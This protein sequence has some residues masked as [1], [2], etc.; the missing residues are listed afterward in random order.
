VFLFEKG[1]YQGYPV[2]T[3]VFVVFVLVDFVLPGACP[4]GRRWFD[5][6]Q[7]TVSGHRDGECSGI[8]DCN[9]ITGVCMCPQ[10]YEG[11]ACNIKKCL[12]ACSGHGRCLDMQQYAAEPTAFPLRNTLTFQYLDDGT[13]NTWDAKMNRGCLCD[14]SWSV[15]L[16][17]GETQAAEWFGPDCSL[18]RCPSGDDTWTTVVETD[19]TGKTDNGASIAPTI[20]TS[21]TSNVAAS[22]TVTTITHVA[23]ARG[24]AVGDS[25]TISGHTGNAANTAMNQIFV[26]KTVTSPTVAVLTG[27]GMTAATYN[28]GTIKATFSMAAKGNLCH[29]ECSNRG[30]CDYG[31]G[32][33]KCFDGWKGAACTSQITNPTREME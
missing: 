30:L 23:G 19:C 27:T 8:G 10:G 12:N 3:I 4:Y 33:C 21:V 31:K 13:S 5:I 7:S 14:T 25:V 28:T 9:R 32:E 17:A 18:R 20:E 16:D 2:L 22:A 24:F 26:V 15:G 29:V 11:K 6:A 1:N